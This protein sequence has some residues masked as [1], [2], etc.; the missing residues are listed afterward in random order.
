[1]NDRFAQVVTPHLKFLG[2]RPLTPE[3]SLSALGM[4]SMQAINVLFDLE[5]AFEVSLPDDEL[6]EQT[7]ATVGSLWAALFRA[8]DAQ[9]VA[10]EERAAA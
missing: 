9:G 10:L 7:F 4:D 1:M 8:A 6:N 3:A 5:D 2:D